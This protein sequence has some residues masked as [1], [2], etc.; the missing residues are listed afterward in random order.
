[1]ALHEPESARGS[2]GELDVEGDPA[3][4]PG[5]SFG[6]YT[7][8]RCVG[9]G[10]MG[11]VYEAR[12]RELGKR[13]ALKA[14][15]R[16]VAVDPRARARFLAEGRA[17][18]RLRHPHVVDVS[19]HGI[20]DGVPF[21]VMEFLEGETL[22][23][24]I[25]REGALP[26]ARAAEIMLPV[27]AA[28]S[29]THQQG[30][31]HRDLKP[32]NI[33]L[34]RDGLGREQVKVLDF[35]VSRIES[36]DVDGLTSTGALIGTP[37]YMSPEQA[38]DPRNARA[39]SDQYTIGVILAECVTGRRAFEGKSL[40]PVLRNIVMG[41]MARPRSLRPDL[42]EDFEAVVLRAAHVDISARYDSVD[43][44]ARALLP[45][46]PR[47]SRDS[48]R[49]V[50]G[51]APDPTAVDEPPVVAP[52]PTPPTPPTPAPTAALEAVVAPAVV[53]SDTIPPIARP[54][55]PRPRGAA[56]AGLAAVAALGLGLGWWV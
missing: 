7:V 46:A 13:V 12:H 50:F 56:V 38:Q 3:L 28:V 10:G 43:D 9:R 42:P 29:A 2:G 53:S 11:A 35:G 49:P 27:C 25:A 30:I 21:L 45:Y 39:P 37:W 48:W 52:A 17:T 32:A 8:E 20:L 41:A 16:R 26:V 47:L 44:L 55:R 19:D 54:L 1:M 36:P 4:A 5:A 51:V 23:A 31:V 24:L 40:Y 34:S 22:E 14:L 15:H 18:S 33:F 6:A